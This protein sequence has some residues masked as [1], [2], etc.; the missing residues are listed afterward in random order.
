MTINPLYLRHMTLKQINNA[1]NERLH[2]L[3]YI[4]DNNHGPKLLAEIE[5]LDERRCVI[6]QVL[7]NEGVKK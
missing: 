7:E 3:K 2:L 5:V 4:T 1:I 6:E